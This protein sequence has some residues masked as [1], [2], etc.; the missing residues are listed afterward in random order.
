MQDSQGGVVPNTKVTLLNQEQGAVSRELVTSTEG[1]F[2]F[3][4]VIPGTYTV[5]VEVSGFKRYARR[6]IAVFAQDRIGLP[7]IVLEVGTVG[8][9]INVE[10]GAVTLQTVRGERS[11]VLTGSEMNELASST[12]LYSDLL[13]TIPGFNEDTQNAN[14]LRTDQ[15]AIAVDGTLVTDVG[16]NSAGGW[17]LN[18]DIIAEFKVLTN[19][20]QAEFGRA[21]GSKLDLDPDMVEAAMKG[22]ATF[23]GTVWLG[24]Y[25]QQRD[26]KRDQAIR[27]ISSFSPVSTLGLPGSRSDRFLGGPWKIGI[28]TPDRHDRDRSPVQFLP[29]IIDNPAALWLVT[30]N[31]LIPLNKCG[32]NSM[33]SGEIGW[34]NGQDRIV[35]IAVP[36]AFVP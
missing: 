1:T 29:G 18:T 13:P 7:P 20:Q 36:A 11:G 16:N 28:N 34:L 26:E 10:A 23:R 31:L 30:V 2:S 3:T 35:R 9:T 14:G 12:R 19:G 15:N 32:S 6:D 24:H 27:I 17:R 25:Y 4:P 21:S 33:G 5:R 22:F 8:E